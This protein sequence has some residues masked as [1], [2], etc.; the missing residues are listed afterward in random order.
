M[1]SVKY[2][3]EIKVSRCTIIHAQHKELHIFTDASQVAYGACAYIRSYNNN[4]IAVRLLCAKGRVAP[5][6]TIS[7]PRL[8]LCG[9]LVG[10]QLYNKI[11]NS[12]RLTLEKICI[13]LDRFHNRSRL[14]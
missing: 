6:K 14:A 10:A 1:N 11:I 13:F 9:A 7:I 3:P 8:E 5:L 12:L 2:L 4:E